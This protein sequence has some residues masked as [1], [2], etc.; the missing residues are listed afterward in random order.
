MAK[1]VGS[2][3]ALAGPHLDVLLYALT[4]EDAK[5]VRS[6]QIRIPDALYK[7]VAESVLSIMEGLETTDGL[8]SND[9]LERA[10]ALE[11]GAVLSLRYKPATGDIEIAALQNGNGM[12]LSA[13]MEL[14]IG[15]QEFVNISADEL[16]YDLMKLDAAQMNELRDELDIIALKFG[17][18]AL[19]TGLSKLLK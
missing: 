2:A 14:S 10:Q 18:F 8:I 5:G 3:L 1:T 16:Q 17:K 6:M 12:Q 11:G 13:K 9:L 4:T 19:G 7:A 15:E